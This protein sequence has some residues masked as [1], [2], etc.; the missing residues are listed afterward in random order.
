MPEQWKLVG[1]A[2]SL[3]ELTKLISKHF[4]SECS[5]HYD[6]FL[7]FYRV[8]NSKGVI[9]GVRVIEKR[10]RFRFERSTV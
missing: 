2:S 9:P 5:T 7:G 10:K 1:S 6:S 4:Y 8:T 3:D